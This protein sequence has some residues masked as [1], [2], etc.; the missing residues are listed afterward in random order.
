M[1]KIQKALIAFL[2]LTVFHHSSSQVIT[3][4]HFQNLTSLDGLVSNDITD[5]LIQN[6]S[7]IWIATSS[8]LSH[9][10][11]ST[12]TNYTSATSMIQD[13]NLRELAYAQN[14]IWAVS[15]SGLTSFDGTSFN[16]YN[17]SNGLLNSSI[18]GIAATSND[19]LWITGLS[20]TSKFDGSTFTNYPTQVGRDIEVDNMDRVYVMRSSVA[21]NFP[22]VRLYENGTWSLPAQTGINFGIIGAKLSKTSEGNLFVGGL[23]GADY[24]KINYPLNLDKKTVYF[25]SNIYV[26]GSGLAIN[27]QQI[28]ESKGL[29][30]IGGGGNVPLYHVS[31]DSNFV[32]QYASSAG[33]ESSVIKIKDNIMAIGSDRGI[34]LSKPSIKTSTTRLPFSVNQIATSVSITDPLFSNLISGSANFE[35]PKNNNS[36]G[37]FAANFIVAAKKINQLSSVVHPDNG[38][39]QAFNPGPIHNSGGVSGEYIFRLTEAEIVAH[40]TLYNQPGY[41]LPTGIRDWP[42]IGDTVLGVA[43]DLAPFVDFNGNGCYDPHN[44]DYPII[45]GDEAIYWINHPTDTSLELEYHWMMYAFDDTTNKNLDQSIF[46]QYT[47]INRSIDVYDSLKVGLVV[48][49]DLGNPVDD[50]IGSDSLY[51]IIYFYN[52]DNFDES[53]NGFNGYGNQAPALGVKFLSDSLDNALTFNSGF[54]INGDPVVDQDWVNYLNSRWKNGQAVVFGG[55]GIN[56]SGGAGKLTRY[57]Y[58]GQPSTLSGWTEVTP[59]SSTV[60]RNAPGDRRMLGSIPHFSLQPQERKTI[61]IVVGYGQ[62]ND[63]SNVT[64]KNIPEMVSILNGAERFWELLASPTATFASQDS[65]LL[66]TSLSNIEPATKPKIAIYPVPAQNRIT[67]ESSIVFDRLEIYDM[68]GSL[69]Y[70]VGPNQLIINIDVSRLEEGVYFVNGYTE[71]SVESRKFLIIR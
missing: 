36:H 54:G 18:E 65:C 21:N 50:Y 30:F 3:T 22:F 29:S 61:E 23:N 51:N 11:G 10:D 43:L 59:L 67:I 17:I 56:G 20:G 40:Q 4:Q 62:T 14:K 58:T 70:E 15:A 46:L 28:E 60:F 66:I 71:K 63:T 39:S 55:D 13:N 7:N 45:R 38:F 31:T 47:I 52:G 16:N 26:P 53:T 64:G 42:A 32:Q 34:F 41:A 49:G 24:V 69:V 8:G 5:I 33:A 6:D 57:M 68:K 12:F 48:D 44:G 2:L 1:N 9:Y 37:I 19:T 27:L 35:F 25:D